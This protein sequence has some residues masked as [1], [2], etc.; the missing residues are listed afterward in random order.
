MLFNTATL[1]REG[2]T[3]AMESVKSLG[4]AQFS[5]L[6]TGGVKPSGFGLTQGLA[7]S[8]TRAA[9]AKQNSLAF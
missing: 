2:L 7:F 3:H 9:C 4:N 1:S 5:L 8:P 6:M